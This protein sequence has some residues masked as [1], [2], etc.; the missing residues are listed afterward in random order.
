M[1]AA[2]T[3]FMTAKRL[4]LANWLWIILVIGA[5][6]AAFLWFRAQE[7]ADDKA[8]QE[9]GENRAVVQ[10]QATTL[11]QIGAANEAGNNVR[12]GASSAKFDECLRSSEKGYERSCDRYKPVEPMSD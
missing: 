3:A 6:G 4:G 8:N 1:I 5:L 7:K 12:A 11:N 2:I 10:G 9:I